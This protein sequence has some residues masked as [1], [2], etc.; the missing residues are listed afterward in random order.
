MGKSRILLLSVYCRSNSEQQSCTDV[1]IKAELYNFPHLPCCDGESCFGR[2]CTSW[3]CKSATGN[4]KIGAASV[5]LRMLILHVKR[6]ARCKMCEFQLLTFF[7]SRR[8][9][10]YLKGIWIHF[11]H[12][13]SIF[14]FTTI[15]YNVFYQFV[16]VVLVRK[17]QIKPLCFTLIL[18][19]KCRCWLML[20]VPWINKTNKQQSNDKI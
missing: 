11:L 13:F 20:T 2:L 4:M 14:I 19:S 5:S 18:F 17:R 1:N 8:C 9:L 3:W 15:V 16:S 10:I 12:F 7:L 6:R